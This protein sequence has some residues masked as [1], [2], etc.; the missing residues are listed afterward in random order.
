MHGLQ[1][2]GEGSSFVNEKE[3][4]FV[5][6]LLSWLAVNN[7]TADQVGIITLYKAQV[8]KIISQMAQQQCR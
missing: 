3:A 1:K 6:D 8:C 2:F 5:C 7:V 4:K